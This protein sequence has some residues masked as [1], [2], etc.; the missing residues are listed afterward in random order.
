MSHHQERFEVASKLAGT[1]FLE[2]LNYYAAAWLPARDLVWT[3]ME[4][5][6]EVDPS[7]Q[8]VKFDRVSLQA[9]LTLKSISADAA[10]RLHQSLPWK[11]HLHTLEASLRPLSNPILYILYPEGDGEQSNWRIQAVPERP[12]SFESRKAL[13]ERFGWLYLKLG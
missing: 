12:D 9:F 5:R 6:F 7:G 11:E 2:R 3:A 1:E 8:I 13:P 4:K 10:E